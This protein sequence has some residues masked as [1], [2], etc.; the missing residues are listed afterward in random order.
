MR[1]SLDNL[2]PGLF[3]A[4]RF[5][6]RKVAEHSCSTVPLKIPWCAFHIVQRYKPPS[7][8]SSQLCIKRNITFTFCQS[9]K[10]YGAVVQQVAHR[11]VRQ[12]TFAHVHHSDVCGQSGY[13]ARDAR[14]TGCQSNVDL[15]ES[16]TPFYVERFP[17][18]CFSLQL[19]NSPEFLESLR[20]RY[21]GSSPEVRRWR[22]GAVLARCHAIE[23]A[24][25]RVVSC[26]GDCFD[27]FGRPISLGLEQAEM[28]AP[29]DGRQ[30]Q[31]F[32]RCHLVCSRVIHGR[33]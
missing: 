2:T 31:A 17:Q 8:R 30:T 10:M 27:C 13:D 1:L 24:G 4:E 26:S 32:Q 18:W 15:D 21:R 23:S 14:S 9:A 19:R 29:C 6:D 25:L 11:A 5:S 7:S 16:G 33:R 28:I 3:F 22:C 20:C 12:D